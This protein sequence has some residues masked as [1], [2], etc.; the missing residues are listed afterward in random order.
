MLATILYAIDL[1]LKEGQS[2]RSQRL[3]RQ[4]LSSVERGRNLTTRLLSFAKTY[5]V[6]IRSETPTAAEIS[7]MEADARAAMDG[8]VADLHP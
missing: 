2:A 3:L 4:A 5:Y 1:A 8:L 7:V 6:T